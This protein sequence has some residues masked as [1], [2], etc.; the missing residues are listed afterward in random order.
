MTATFDFSAHTILVTG[1]NGTLGVALVDAL[2]TAGARVIA[3]YHERDDVVSERVAGHPDRCRSMQASLTDKGAIVAMLDTLT[4]SGWRPTGLVNNAADQRVGELASMSMSAWREMQATNVDAVFVLGQWAAREMSGGAIVNVSS[5]EGADP[6]PGHAHYA[7]SK[8][9]LNMLTKAL[10]QELG[11]S[12]IRVNAVSP[13]LIRRDGI[14]TAW[15]EGVQSWQDKAPLGRLGE[16]QEVAQAVLFLLSDA[17]A[18]I[19]G[20][21]LVV[22]G[23]MSVH[24]RW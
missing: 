13:G 14:E 1:A 7:T 12:N 22:D 8:A 24:P 19:T 6:A 10:A 4:G 11:S 21:N 2:L 15:P 17:A 20:S 18:W 9:A 23:G 3:H 16:A 5:I